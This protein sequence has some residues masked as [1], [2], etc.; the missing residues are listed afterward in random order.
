MAA[1]T[2]KARVDHSANEETVG[3]GYYAKRFA[4]NP[5]NGWKLVKAD[6]S[7]T[8]NLNGRGIPIVGYQTERRRKLIL[9]RREAEVQAK[10]V[11]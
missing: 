5:K 7:P 11:A 4:K 1:V 9:K 10:K 8:I 2:P 6:S 3:V